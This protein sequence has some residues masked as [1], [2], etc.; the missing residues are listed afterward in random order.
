MTQDS[1]SLV[2]QRAIEVSTGQRTQLLRHLIQHSGSKATLVFVAS[3]YAAEVVADKLRKA[4]IKAEPFH[5]ELNPGK[6]AQVLADF[7]ASRLSVIVAN[8]GALS[9]LD[10]AKSDCV[11]NYDLPR[12]A[13][14]YQL[15][16]QPALKAGESGRV[17]NFVSPESLGHWRLIQKRQG[18][19][20]ESEVIAGYEP[21]KTDAL[22]EVSAAG[23][24]GKRPSKKDK[25]RAEISGNTEPSGDPASA[26][27]PAQEGL[28]GAS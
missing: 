16:I 17:V 27:A 7:K 22:P 14:D 6:R 25:L 19:S 23:I 9:G 15:R 13:A 12:A 5:S 8:D 26:Q 2:V 3:K 4:G 24:K 11:V 21:Q 1:I 20:I 10:I 28:T 18:L